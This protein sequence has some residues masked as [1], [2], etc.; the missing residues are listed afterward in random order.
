M[1]TKENML[2]VIIPVYNTEQYLE[3]C[4]KSVLMQTYQNIEVILVDDGSTDHSAVICKKVAHDDKRVTYYR[5]ENGGQ[6]RARNYA[7]DRC[8]GGWISFIDSDD[9]IFPD[10][11]E[12]MILAAEQNN[13][14]IVVC[15]WYRDH[16]FLKREQ[17]HPQKLQFYD[18]T[19]FIK[20]YIQMPYITSSVC[21][22]I[23]RRW[24]WEKERFPEYRAK[25]DA[26]VIY[27]VL[28]KVN[29]A[30]HIGESKYVQYVRPGSTERR[31]YTIDKMNGLQNEK[32][33][34]QF[35]IDNYPKLSNLVA[36]RFAKYCAYLMGEILQGF[37]Y[38]ENRK[39][40]EELFGCLKNELKKE[41][42]FEI[43]SDL[44]FRELQEII[45][46]QAR[47]KRKMY[48]RGVYIRIFDRMK[49][50]LEL[51]NKEYYII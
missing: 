18:N 33:L 13:A 39:I 5:L 48:I 9:Y 49:S 28:A 6:G 23:Y 22:K 3:K 12:K 10:M 45:E 17:P 1:K 35:V 16:G 11:A 15:G 47:F 7:L 38:K 26:C 19:E 20:S 31:G 50:I 41:Y 43:R 25:E 29:I 51:M 37:S 27:K 40:Y 21:N 34:R 24:I 46:N 4:L 30:V 36:L 8:H 44:K 2:S 32:E 42:S 14:D